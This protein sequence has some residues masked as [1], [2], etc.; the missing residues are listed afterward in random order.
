[1]SDD[2]KR[3]LPDFPHKIG[4]IT[5]K[6]GAVI[7]DFS[8]NLG[9]WGFAIKFVDSRVEGKEALYDLLQA[10]KTLEKQNLDVLIIMRG[11]GSMQSLAAFDNE[12]VVR[13][14][15]IFPVPVIAAIGHHQDV[16]LAA[17][18]ADQAVS[19]PTAA[20]LLVG[21][22]W[23][24]AEKSLDANTY[25]IKAA[26][27]ELL[28]EVALTLQLRKESIAEKFA[29]LLR[30]FA[31]ASDR[32]AKAVTRMRETVQFSSTN[33]K[34]THTRLANAYARTV[35]EAKEVLQQTPKYYAV[36]AHILTD[37]QTYLTHY[38]KDVSLT[39]SVQTSSHHLDLQWHERIKRSFTFAIQAQQPALEDD[40]IF[41]SYVNA[42]QQNQTS[43]AH[44]EQIITLNNPMRL[45]Q[46]GYSILK[47]GE[48]L[49][50][51]VEDVTIGDSI[52]ILISDGRI[53]TKV[54]KTQKNHG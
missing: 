17:L 12:S 6:Q 26:Y 13:A 41:K 14:I 24:D 8:N 52:E 48:R 10:M 32:I 42:I 4:I 23:E 15:A 25:T 22:T 50:K 20:A 31:K 37:N 9:T 3:S 16:P 46:H 33:I 29:G 18:V 40:S 49:V 7:H 19:T 28:H 54:L 11:G 34:E 53:K 38:F 2:R 21:S 27:Q 44:C 36:F 1:M 39:P 30:V 5:S 47:N 45:L 51:R 43:L 35:N